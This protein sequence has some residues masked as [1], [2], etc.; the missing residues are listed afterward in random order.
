MTIRPPAPAP[1]GAPRRLLSLLLLL[2]LTLSFAAAPA[3]AQTPRGRSFMS[4]RFTGMGTFITF[5]SDTG[6]L[7]RGSRWS[8]DTAGCAIPTEAEIAALA[9]K[10]LNA[11]HVYGETYDVS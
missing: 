6:T 11:L 3:S 1:F 7:L 8:T 9:S 5:V 2:V 4:A 10:G